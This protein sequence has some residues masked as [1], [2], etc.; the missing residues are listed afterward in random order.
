MYTRAWCQRKAKR[1]QIYN[2]VDILAFC[3]AIFH[4]SLSNSSK[5]GRRTSATTI[6]NR[7]IKG[8]SKWHYSVFAIW[9]Y[10]LST[11]TFEQGIGLVVRKI[12]KSTNKL[13]KTNSTIT[14][15]IIFQTYLI[16]LLYCLH[17]FAFFIVVRNFKPFAKLA[18]LWRYDL[19]TFIGRFCKWRP[20]SI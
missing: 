20:I 18:D 19:R 4:S 17:L 6:I 13:T 8:F 10:I 14:N 1:F 5:H 7:H 2:K 11:C 9:W 12:A 3:N 16:L 15:N